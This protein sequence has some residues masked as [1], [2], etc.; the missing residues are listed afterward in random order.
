MAS[1]I[2]RISNRL[3]YQF[4]G[5]A[6]GVGVIKNK[7]EGTY[8][9]SEKYWDKSSSAKRAVQKSKRKYLRERYFRINYI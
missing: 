8:S 3:L 1:F 5:L 9:V 4:D 7:H 6:L 2:Q